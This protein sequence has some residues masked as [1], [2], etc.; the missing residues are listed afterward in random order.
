MSTPLLQISE[1]DVTAWI[2][3]RV[4]AERQEGTGMGELELAVEQATRECRRRALEVLV[5]EQAAAQPLVCPVCERRLN[6]EAYA[7]T[8]SVNSSFGPVS[9]RRDYG[10]CGPCGQH[11]YPA[12]AALGLH[13]RA[14]GSPRVQELSAL[15][16]L[17]GPTAQHAEDF[18][19]LT[20][21]ALDPSTVH[22]EARRQ[23]VKRLVAVAFEGETDPA[24]AGLVDE[25]VEPSLLPPRPATVPPAA[26]NIP[27][28]RIMPSKSR[29]VAPSARRTP[30]SRVRWLTTNDIT[31]YTPSAAR[32]SATKP[33]PS[34]RRDA[35]WWTRK[36]DLM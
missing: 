35:S 24:L 34:R 31:P 7:R 17:R 10:F 12:D 3:E 21:L 20:G 1:A 33:R 22:R 19:R 26:R 9:F 13:P 2:T 30:N 8:R 16:A 4:R 28:R 5:H 6:V 14:T 25:I 18:R 23:G 15:H 36:A 11:V 27:S 29:A 32:T